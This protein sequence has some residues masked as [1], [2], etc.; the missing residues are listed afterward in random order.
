MIG[1][2]LAAAGPVAASGPSHHPK[3]NRYTVTTLVTGPSPDADL[4]N[5]WGLSRSPTSPWWVVDNGDRTVDPV[6]RQRI[7]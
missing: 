2:L 1:L 4:V 7:E 6:H 3:S 5:G